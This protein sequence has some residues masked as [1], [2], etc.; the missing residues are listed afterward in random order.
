M[1]KYLNLIKNFLFA[2][3]IYLII[4]V[5][6]IYSAY[7]SFFI[8]QNIYN[9]FQNKTEQQTTARSS[10]ELNL[11]LYQSITNAQDAKQSPNYPA[12]LHNPFF[13]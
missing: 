10:S 3:Y 13:R 8:F 4:T 2:N 5:I 12:N 9:I 7:L 1:K 11:D 6:S